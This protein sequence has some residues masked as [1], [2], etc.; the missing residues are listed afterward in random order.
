MSEHGLMH[1]KDKTIAWNLLGLHQVMRECSW[2]SKRVTELVHTSGWRL[3]WLQQL[4]FCVPCLRS[5]FYNNN[6]LIEVARVVDSG[7][8]LVD[9]W[10]LALNTVALGLYGDFI[11]LTTR[12]SSSDVTVIM[13]TFDTLIYRYENF[14]WMYKYNGRC[15]INTCHSITKICYFFIYVCLCFYCNLDNIYLHMHV[16]I[17]GHLSPFSDRV[18]A[19]PYLNIFLCALHYWQTAVTELLIRPKFYSYP[20]WY[21]TGNTRFA[22]LSL[23]LYYNQ[24]S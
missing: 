4:C 21:F 19:C 10:W 7:D 18:V 8:P 14:R 22:K 3:R 24:H 20:I 13:F 2:H 17:T 9:N 1:Y 12:H 23:K 16:T 6:C 5:L 15:L 11:L